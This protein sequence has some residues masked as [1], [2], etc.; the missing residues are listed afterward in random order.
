MKA[1]GNVGMKIWGE[2]GEGRGETGAERGGMITSGSPSPGKMDR[3]LLERDA[4]QR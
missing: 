2:G 1:R 4:K 3:A